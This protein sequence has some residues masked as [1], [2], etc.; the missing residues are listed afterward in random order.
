VSYIAAAWV[1]IELDCADIVH[2]D[3]AANVNFATSGCP[4]GRTSR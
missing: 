1:I 4:P 3:A 2:D